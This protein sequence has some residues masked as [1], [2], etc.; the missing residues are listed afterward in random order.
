MEVDALSEQHLPDDYDVDIASLE[1]AT[2]EEPFL[3]ASFEL[4]KEARALTSIASGIVMGE[5]SGHSRNGAILC[6]HLVRMTKLMRT[7]IHNIV[8]GHGG[9]QELPLM[10]QFLDSASTLIYLLDDDLDGSRFQS[11]LLDSLIAEREFLL[12]VRRQVA[13]R[14]GQR[15]PIEARIERSIADTFAS[16]GLDET[17]IP[18]RRQNGWPSAQ[19]RIRLLG[20]VAYGGLQDW[21]RQYPRLLA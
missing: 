16:A 14:G 21:L 20:P 18:S 12:D 4:L 10:R 1:N 3:R 7:M 19:E 9:E 8:H 11:Y 6:G 2:S 17:K 15:L 5:T 13:E